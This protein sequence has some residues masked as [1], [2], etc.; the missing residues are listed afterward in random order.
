VLAR[1]ALALGEAVA[2]L[3]WVT[4]MESL[5]KSHCVYVTVAVLAECQMP[6]ASNQRTPPNKVGA[7]IGQSGSPSSQYEVDSFGPLQSP[8]FPDFHDGSVRGR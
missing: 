2:E 1:A 6:P 4:P 5:L 3:S 8:N 7:L